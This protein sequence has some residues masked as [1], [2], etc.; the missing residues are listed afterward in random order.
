MQETISVDGYGLCLNDLVTND[1]DD[2]LYPASINGQNYLTLSSAT[3]KSIRDVLEDNTKK[4]LVDMIDDFNQTSQS[5]NFLWAAILPGRLYLY[6]P[7]RPPYP[8]SMKDH[9]ISAINTEI[10]NALKYILNRVYHENHYGK[11]TDKEFDKQFSSFISQ[12]NLDILLDDVH[13]GGMIK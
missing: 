5:R 8:T 6:A 10:W 2:D 9:T 13:D 12:D 3:T 1:L 4:N 7:S 11:L